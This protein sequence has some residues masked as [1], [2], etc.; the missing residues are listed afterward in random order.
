MATFFMQL[1]AV[2]FHL[3]DTWKVWPIDHLV[4]NLGYSN[5]LNFLLVVF[6]FVYLYTSRWYAYAYNKRE[7]GC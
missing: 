5:L 3:L 2:L 7:L 1:G 6:Y 4:S